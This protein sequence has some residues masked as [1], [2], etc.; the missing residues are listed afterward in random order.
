MEV[1]NIISAAGAPYM[2]VSK[3]RTSKVKV[4]YWV[5]TLIFTSFML[6]DGISGV[7]RVEGGKEVMVQLGYP[8][9]FLTILGAGKILGAIALVQQR[10]RTIRE[11]AFAGFTINFLSASA[12]WAF[13][14]KDPVAVA[15]PLVALAILFT[16]YSLWKKVCAAAA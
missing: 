10:F 5:I 16:L 6:M 11:W 4:W 13:V 1:T 2:T 3:S 12:S 15:V 14:V 7:M 9:Y 8:L